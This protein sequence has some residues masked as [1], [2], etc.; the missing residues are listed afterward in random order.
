MGSELAAAME[1]LIWVAAFAAIA[2][3]AIVVTSRRH[4]VDGR[5]MMARVASVWLT[6][7][8]VGVWH[9]TLTPIGD[10]HS[11]PGSNVNIF[12]RIDL[13]NAVA[14]TALLMPVGFLARISSSRSSH[15]N[16]EALALCV[17]VSLIVE[18]TQLV[19][20]LGRSA[21]V[22][23]LALNML[24]GLAGVLVASAALHLVPWPR[25]GTH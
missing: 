23:D 21:D 24:G 10:I 7:A 14:N 25:A 20:G 9:A 22:Q 5:T 3:T 16:A 12:A 2:S 15:P 4:D 8:L 1:D 17:A 6:A 11:H 13:R 19:V 18:G